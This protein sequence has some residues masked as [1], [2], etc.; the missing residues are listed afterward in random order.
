MM[1][2]ES[3][4]VNDLLHAQEG[5]E[6]ISGEEELQ[7]EG[8]IEQHEEEMAIHNDETIS[9]FRHALEASGTFHS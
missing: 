2:E 6:E 9:S 8:V 4:S 1:E 7:Q 5:G 3:G